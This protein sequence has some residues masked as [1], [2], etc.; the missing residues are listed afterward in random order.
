MLLDV[1][2]LQGLDVSGKTAKSK[3]NVVL[4]LENLLEGR[5][6]CLEI[7]SK[8]SISCDS[9]AAFASHGNYST[10]VV[11]KWIHRLLLYF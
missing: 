10:T 7:C 5:A 2:D 6:D 9:D 4:N 1:D 11:R 3:E 8:S